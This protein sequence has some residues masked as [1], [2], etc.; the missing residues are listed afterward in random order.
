MARPLSDVDGSLAGL[1][2]TA[3]YGLAA[4][5]RALGRHA[6]PMLGAV[7]GAPSG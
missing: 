4:D 6:S 7:G 5:I 3:W 2:R 1:L